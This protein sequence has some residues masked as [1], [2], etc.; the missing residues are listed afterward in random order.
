MF[1]NATLYAQQEPDKL[2]LFKPVALK[3]Q[4]PPSRDEVTDGEFNWFNTPAE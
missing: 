1:G 2:E 4:N 3:L